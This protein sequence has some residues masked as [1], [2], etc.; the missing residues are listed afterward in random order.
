MSTLTIQL[1]N[2]VCE[3]AKR[4][5]SQEGVSVDQFVSSAVAEKL[6]ALDTERYLGERTERGRKVDI[7]AI[8]AKVPAVEP[9][10]ADRLPG[11]KQ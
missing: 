11:T 3:N 1:P 4:L 8:L 6:A 7:D 9:A 2:S 10:P 5:A